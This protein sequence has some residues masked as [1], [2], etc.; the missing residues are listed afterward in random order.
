MCIL[1][2]AR[3]RGDGGVRV[4]WKRKQA[5]R[6]A[7]NVIKDFLFL[8]FNFILFLLY[9]LVWLQSRPKADPKQTFFFHF[10]EVSG[11][12]EAVRPWVSSC[13]LLP[14]EPRAQPGDTGGAQD[15]QPM[16]SVL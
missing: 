6:L 10:P 11:G 16:L 9:E 13:I 1:G 5:F 15:L 12:L 8:F 3:T 7:G 14:A 4:C 2:N